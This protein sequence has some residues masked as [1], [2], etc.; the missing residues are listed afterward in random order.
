MSV[1][2]INFGVTNNSPAYMKYA[3]PAAPAENNDEQ[4][5]SLTL[6]A[7]TVC[8]KY[9]VP[10]KPEKNDIFANVPLPKYAIPSAPQKDKKTVAD[11]FRDLLPQNHIMKYA[12]PRG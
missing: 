10:D 4:T 2:K 1:K 11:F 6:P 9:A 7:D 12:V 5:Q 3:I 8:I